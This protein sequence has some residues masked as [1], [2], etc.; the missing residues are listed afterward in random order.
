MQLSEGYLVDVE[1]PKPEVNPR[2]EFLTL[3]IAGLGTLAA[4]VLIGLLLQVGVVRTWHESTFDPIAEWLQTSSFVVD[5]SEV[6][7]DLGHFTVN[8]LMLAALA[9]LAW[10]RF[11]R[12]AISWWVG[13]ALTAVALRPFQS[14]VSRL[15]DGSSPASPAVIGTSGPYFSGGVFRVV[16]IAALTGMILQLR[17]RTVLVF[18][19]L[20]GVVEGLTRMAL[21]RHWPL[22]IVAAIPIGLVVALIVGRAVIALSV[23]ADPAGQH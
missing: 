7:T 15:V 20:A 22:D 1:R 8:Y 4:S 17:S 11:G 10:L 12:G 6:L 13:L 18:A 23:L 21:G 16:V 3:G 14:L 2:S 19:A 5:V 9:V